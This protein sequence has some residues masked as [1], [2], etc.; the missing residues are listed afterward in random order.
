MYSEVVIVLL[1][2][3]GGADIDSDE[4]LFPSH[5]RCFHPSYCVA[6]EREI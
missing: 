4:D 2:E 5:S 3:Y 1:G 6:K